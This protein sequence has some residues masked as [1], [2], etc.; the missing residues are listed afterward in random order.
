MNKKDYMDRIKQKE[1]REQRRDIKRILQDFSIK[2]KFNVRDV[3]MVHELIKGADNK[4]NGQHP[5]SIKKDVAI[6]Q[7]SFRLR[8]DSEYQY[9]IEV[10]NKL[11][12]D[13]SLRRFNQLKLELAK[14][15]YLHECKI[16]FI[17]LDTNL[18]KVF[19]QHDKNLDKIIKELKEIHTLENSAGVYKNLEKL[20]KSVKALKDS[21]LIKSRL[22]SDDI[23]GSQ[24]NELSKDYIT[25]EDLCKATGRTNEKSFYALTQKGELK[26][27]YSSKASTMISAREWYAKKK[28]NQYKS[29]EHNIYS[30]GLL[31]LL[32]SDPNSL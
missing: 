32:F 5:Y 12:F 31:I 14:S 9:R 1:Q 24:S 30:E 3:K 4:N 10:I 2:S 20:I 25:F 7:N 26:S 29:V 19:F 15:I 16:N 23:L 28:F 17:K 8:P 21:L 11:A 6:I 13:L 22:N 27:H 18:N